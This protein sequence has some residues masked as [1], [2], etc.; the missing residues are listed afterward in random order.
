MTR[1]TWTLAA[2]TQTGPFR[3]WLCVLEDDTEV[4]VPG[5]RIAPSTLGI[6][7]AASVVQGRSY[8]EGRALQL[9][10]L[11]GKAIHPQS[12]WRLQT[13]DFGAEARR[14]DSEFLMC[15]ACESPGPSLS[16][17]TPYVEV[18]FGLAAGQDCDP[19]FELTVKA[20]RGMPTAG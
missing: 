11:I 1:C 19:V 14:H 10:T 8:L 16:C 3:D 9:V 6:A 2:E 13:I 5:S 4:V 17:G 15:F 20:V 18:G 7:K 12:T